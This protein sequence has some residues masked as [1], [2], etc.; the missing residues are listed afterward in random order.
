MKSE[1]IHDQGGSSAVW[2]L[3]P[4]ERS[5]A[6]RP[7]V[8]GI[9]LLAGAIT[10]AVVFKLLPFDRRVLKAR[11]I[12]EIHTVL[13]LAATGVWSLGRG[14]GIFRTPGASI[15]VR[16]GHLLS[17][18]G[19]AGE[20]GIVDL[21]ASRV[22]RLDVRPV[23]AGPGPYIFLARLS[24]LGRLVA[25]LDDRSQVEVVPLQDRRTLEEL[26]AGIAAALALAGSHVEVFSLTDG[27]VPELEDRP[28]DSRPSSIEVDEHGERTRI[29]LA[30]MARGFGRY[31]ATHLAGGLVLFLLG[32]GTAASI[33][34][35]PGALRGPLALIASSVIILPIS[36][37]C[38]SIYLAF[39]SRNFRQTSTTIELAG[40]SLL[41][42]EGLKEGD[43]RSSSFNFSTVEIGIQRRL[44]NCLSLPRGLVIGDPSIAPRVVLRGRSDEELAWVAAAIRKRLATSPSRPVPARDRGHDLHAGRAI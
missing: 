7:I 18:P 25:V 39:R 14:I 36:F 35:V 17:K 10:L 13:V 20:R 44:Q 29:S 23:E 4:P 6:I 9:F 12:W 26:A 2:K 30:P 21:P 8:L 33:L 28:P 38:L 15:E 5:R 40:D 3:P 41:L 1:T 37:G 24:T 32:A 22:R 16:D 43:E 42:T 31:G 11:G 19:K 27:E 34:S